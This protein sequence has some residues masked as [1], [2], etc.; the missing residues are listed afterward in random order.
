MQAEI[1]IAYILLT[2]HIAC[3]LRLLSNAFNGS[4]DLEAGFNG[5]W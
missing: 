2:T 5:G 1:H 4:V 3:N